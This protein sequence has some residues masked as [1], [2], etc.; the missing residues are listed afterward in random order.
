MVE[1]NKA[2]ILSDLKLL[3]NKQLLAN[4]GAEDHS[5]DRCGNPSRQEHQEKDAWENKEVLAADG[6]TRA[7]VEGKVQSGNRNFN[8]QTW[9]IALA[10]SKHT[11]EVSVQWRCVFI[12][13]MRVFVPP[14]QHQFF[15]PNHS[16]SKSNQNPPGNPANK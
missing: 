15:L 8:P 7:D 13:R 4:Q 16:H 1:K 14:L 5:C 12:A 11:W 10:D 2:N 9:K 3:S 6:T